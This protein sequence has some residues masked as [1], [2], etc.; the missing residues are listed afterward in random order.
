MEIVVNLKICQVKL[1]IMFS[2]SGFYPILFLKILWYW[3][4]SCAD[5]THTHTHTHTRIYTESNVKF[6]G[7]RSQLKASYVFSLTEDIVGQEKKILFLNKD[8]RILIFFVDLYTI[9]TDLISYF[10]S[11]N[12][13][14]YHAAPQEWYTS[15]ITF[16]AILFSVTKMR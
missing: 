7:F 16:K 15:Y 6:G 12:K 9:N 10:L 4:A 2:F 11:P 1:R 8:T 14:Y 3:S 13:K 5:I